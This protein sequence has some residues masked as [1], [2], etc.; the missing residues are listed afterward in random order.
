MARIS[1]Y[2]KIRRKGFGTAIYAN[3]NTAN[4]SFRF[5]E[6]GNTTALDH[7]ESKH[8]IDRKTGELKST[9]KDPSQ[10]SIID[11]NTI[12]TLVFERRFDEFKEL[13]I[14]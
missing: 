11:F 10:P 6:Q 2:G 5:L 9:K 14:R 4:R 1:S 3:S 7:L 13:L 12:S 8:Q